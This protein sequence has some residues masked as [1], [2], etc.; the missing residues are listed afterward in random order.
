VIRAMFKSSFTVGAMALAASALCYFGT[1]GFA[2]SFRA[3]RAKNYN[4]KDLAGI[5]AIA[6]VLS[7]A[8]IALM[9]WSGFWLS[10]FGVFIAGPMWCLVG[11]LV[12]SLTTKREHA[13]SCAA[14]L[15]AVYPFVNIGEK[16]LCIA[17]RNVPKFVFSPR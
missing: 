9:A 6:V 3:R 14:R 16:H 10:L 13:L 7:V 11:I 17:L 5:G 2:G 4:P 15:V 12:A 1:A 8:G